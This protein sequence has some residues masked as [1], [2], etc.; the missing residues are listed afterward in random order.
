MSFDP[1]SSDAKVRISILELKI[2]RLENERS[3][4]GLFFKETSRG[5]NLL[6]SA[7]SKTLKLRQTVIS[8]DK[9]VCYARVGSVIKPN[10]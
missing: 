10:E 6:T 5:E 2:T 1:K 9:Q 8:S 4:P 3:H 7:K